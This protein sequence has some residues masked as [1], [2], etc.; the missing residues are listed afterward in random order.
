[1]RVALAD[2]SIPPVDEQLSDPSNAPTP[3]NNTRLHSGPDSVRIMRAC[4]SAWVRSRRRRWSGSARPA[5]AVSRRGRRGPASS[6]R[7]RTGSAASAGCALPRKRAC[8]FRRRRRWC[9]SRTHA[10][11]RTFPTVPSRARPGEPGALSLDPVTKAED[12]DA[13]SR[14]MAPSAGAGSWLVRPDTCRGGRSE[15]EH[16]RSTHP[17]GRVR[18]RI[19]GM[20]AGAGGRGVGPHDHRLRPRGEP[21]PSPGDPASIPRGA[22]PCPEC[23]SSGKAQGSCLTPSSPPGP[24]RTGMATSPEEETRSHV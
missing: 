14:G 7:G 23:R 6:A 13:S 17:D 24:C 5:R 20:G 10:L 15:R 12:R 19:A 16:G 21:A 1:M 2:D 18:R 8:V 4:R 3:V 22:S 11:R 9:S